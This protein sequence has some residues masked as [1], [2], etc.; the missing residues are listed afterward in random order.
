MRLAAFS[1]FLA[2]LLFA[3]PAAAAALSVCTEASPEGF[4]VVQ[5]NSLTTTNASADVLMNRLVEFDAGKGA[6]VP[7]LAERWTVSDDGLNYRFDLRQDVRFHRTGYFKPSRALNADDV[8]FSFQRMLDPA[9][10][11]HKVA[12]NGFPHAQSMQLPQLIKRVEK[13]GDHQVLFVLDHPDATFLPM[14]S[15]GFASIYSAEYA[16]QLMKAGTPEK[17]NAQPIGSGPFVFKRFQK[18]AVVRYAANPEYFA[19]KPAVDALIFA[20]TPDANVRLQKLRRG[21]CQIALSPKPLDVESA[22]KDASLKVEQ[23][24]AFMTAFV[25]LNTQ[26]PPLDDPEVRQAINLAFDRAS[27]LQAVFE[28]S[29]SAAT[30]IYP[31]NTWGYARD[32]PAYPHDPEQARKLL[33]GKQ[34]AELNI[35]TRPS[36]SLL[37]PNPSLGAQLLQSDLA[38]V[39]IKAS[40]RV[41]EWGELI[42]RA[43]NGEHDLLFMGWAGDNGDPDNFLTPQFSCASVKS[44]L[45]FARYCDPGLDKLIADGKAAS[46]QEQRTGLY[47]QAQKLIHEQALWLPLAHPTAFALT[48]QEVQGYQVN[49][50]GRQDF[51]RVAVKR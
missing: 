25:A 48:R 50:F 6:V 33:A 15:M 4:D 12:Q 31:P 8:V 27:Y 43:K 9:D 28:G 24:P 17:L 38:E 3:Q 26:H 18:D 16:D 23:T 14:L 22:R 35:W 32:I 45:N 46:S 47:H 1:L 5:Y 37:N 20:I 51:S 29:A 7:S 10:P 41:I 19:G 21:E 11:W 13:S 36:G 42:R 49:P 40:I 30:G 2:P 39:G 34:L 44:G